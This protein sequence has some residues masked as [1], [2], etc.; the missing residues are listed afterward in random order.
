MNDELLSAQTLRDAF[1]LLGQRLQEQNLS[2]DV[3]VFGG[4]A[5]VLGFDARP[6]T[7]DVDA[8][9]K[10]Q[11]AVLNVA[12]QVADELG[13]PKWWLNEQAG[14]YLPP[15]A[16]FEGTALFDAP[17]IRVVSATAELLLALKVAAARPGDIDDIRLLARH[18]GI[19]SADLVIALAERTLELTLT[20][21]K[22][23]VIEDLFHP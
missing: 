8:L 17:G 16:A 7:R 23:M 13:L 11:G 12:W 5:M 9:W 19:E 21:R 14:S 10:P 6:G 20:D 4:A 18:L 15:N 3:F 2:A 22:R 1:S